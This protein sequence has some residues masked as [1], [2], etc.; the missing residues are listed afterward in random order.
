MNYSGYRVQIKVLLAFF[1][2]QSGNIDC[3][4]FFV[5]TYC[6]LLSMWIAC[7][8]TPSAASMSGS[9]KVGCAWMVRLR[10]SAVAPASIAKTASAMREDTS[11]PTICTPSTKLVSFSATIWTKPSASETDRALPFAWNGKRLAIVSYPLCLCLAL[12]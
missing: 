4:S 7:P 6:F 11:G 10:S 9:G 5:S 3:P 8:K 12:R 1:F 2:L